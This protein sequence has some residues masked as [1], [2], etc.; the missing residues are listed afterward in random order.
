[1]FPPCALARAFQ[2]EMTSKSE[3]DRESRVRNANIDFSL[4][5]LDSVVHHA[6]DFILSMFTSLE[7]R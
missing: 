7:G 2:P 6:K 4:E 5:T 3:E 1:M